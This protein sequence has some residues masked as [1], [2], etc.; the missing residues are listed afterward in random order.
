[1]SVP[2]RYVLHQGAVVRG[3]GEAALAGL[4]QRFRAQ[5][6]PAG[7]PELPGPELLQEF[8]AR[9]PSLVHS[10]IRHVGGDPAAYR[11]RI[12]PHLFPQWALSMSGKLTADLDYP[13]LAA[14][15]AGCRLV[16][17]APLPSDEPLEVSAQLTSIDDNG[18]RAILTQRFVTGTASEPEALEAELFVYIPLKKTREGAKGA[19][20][21]GA[22]TAPSQQGKES[23]SAEISSAGEASAQKRKARREHRARVPLQVR[24]LATWTLPANAGLEFSKLTGDF[25]PVHWVGPWARAFGFKGTILHGFS[26]LARAMEGLNRNLFSGDVSALSEIEVRFTRPLVLPARVGLFVRGQRLWVGEAPGGPSYLEGRFKAKD[27]AVTEEDGG[28]ES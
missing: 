10:Y 1:M 25:N 4:R 2:L 7:G 24:E 5:A 27:W 20:S 11:G 17:N 12:P 28:G 19:D 23:S 22:Q 9:H 18:R 15:N 3:M 13:L 6:K 14:M 8:A 21:E 26:T 16:Q